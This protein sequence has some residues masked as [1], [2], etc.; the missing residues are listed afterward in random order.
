MFTQIIKSPRFWRKS[1]L[2][3]ISWSSGPV[4]GCW[5]ICCVFIRF[6]LTPCTLIFFQVKQTPSGCCRTRSFRSQQSLKDS[7]QRLKTF[8]QNFERKPTTS[9]P[10]RAES[11][12]GCRRYNTSYQPPT[13][14]VRNSLHSTVTLEYSA[15]TPLFWQLS[16]NCRKCKKSLSGVEWDRKRVQGD[17]NEYPSS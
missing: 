13:P 10:A 16:K 11:Q 8:W 17:I 6:Q 14:T 3:V 7:M 15:I 9:A 2:C 5:G 12:Q 1:D 4:G